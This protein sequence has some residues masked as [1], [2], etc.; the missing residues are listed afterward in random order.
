MGQ[1]H[2]PVSRLTDRLRRMAQDEAVRWA[3]VVFVSVRL[4]LSALAVVVIT[5]LPL[6][7]GGH[8]AYVSSLGLRPVEHPTEELLLEVWQ[9]WDVLHYQ[10]IA[11]Q[12]YTDDESSAY[13]PLFPSLMALL[14]TA[15][16]GNHLL[17]GFLISNLSFLLTLVYLYK[18]TELDH[19][20]EVA[21]RTV[22]YISI[23]PT[24]FY[25][26]IPYS[27]SLYLL[28][29]VLFFHAAR[30]HRWAAT[31][32]AAV[33]A[34]L[35]RFQGSVLLIPWGFEYLEH[36]GFDLRRV[37][38]HV[39]LLPLALVPAVAFLWLRTLAGYAGLAEVLAEHWHSVFGAPWHN[40]LHL[41]ALAT[42]G[43]LSV[44]D[45]LD[46]VI[47]VPFLG[48]VL[49]S[50]LRMRTSY[51]L[52][53]VATLF[54]VLSVVYIPPPLMNIPRHM[55]VFFPTFM[56]MASLAKRSIVHRAIVYSSMALLMLLAGMF[57]QWLWVA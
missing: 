41:W 43:S 40:F 39:L 10:R 3:L 33:L 45:I 13:A 21:R 30:R 55:L 15:L 50:L 37:R 47:T 57:V 4:A 16:G 28:S 24:A 26:F 49:A 35:T 2:S 44:I 56:F 31:C 32:A 22:L 9:R 25:F 1:A 5:F 29:I 27:E 20:E 38:W 6:P 36:I 12:G 51:R 17:A 7:E 46:A 19:S 34:S 14:G 8:E 52:Y 48:L 23:F 54:L 18:L 42:S 53:T 11:A